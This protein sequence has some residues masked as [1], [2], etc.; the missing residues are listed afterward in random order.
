M[1]FDMKLVERSES[2]KTSGYDPESLTMRVQFGEGK[3]RGE[4]SGV[5]PELYQAFLDAP[6]PGSFLRSIIAPACPYR[7]LKEDEE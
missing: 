2:G 4:Y 1:P 3:T 5:T 7:P 6:K